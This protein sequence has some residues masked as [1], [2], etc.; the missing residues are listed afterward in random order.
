[1]PEPSIAPTEVTGTTELRHRRRAPLS[2]DGSS[3]DGRTYD[4]R[5]TYDGQTDVGS[6]VGSE[7]GQAEGVPL[8]VV[9]IIA[10]GVFVTTYLFF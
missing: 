4:G 6:Y 3:Y 7:I 1:M 10:L 2:D 8:Q 5:S 9:I